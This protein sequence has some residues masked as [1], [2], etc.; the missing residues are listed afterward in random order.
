MSI[1][2]TLNFTLTNPLN[3][4]GI[5]GLTPLFNILHIMDLETIKR[6]K[7][8][9][10]RIRARANRLNPSFGQQQQSPQL[11]SS[12][13]M[14]GFMGQNQ[15]GGQSAIKIFKT[16]PKPLTPQEEQEKRFEERL[17]Q[18][19]KDQ[20]E[21]NLSQREAEFERTKLA[22]EQIKSGNWKLDGEAVSAADMFDVTGNYYQQEFTSPTVG[23]RMQSSLQQFQENPMQFLMGG[24]QNIGELINYLNQANQLYQAT[25]QE[26]NFMDSLLGGSQAGAVTGSALGGSYAPQGAAPR[27]NPGSSYVSQGFA[28]PTKLGGAP[29]YFGG[30]NNY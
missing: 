2:I 11:Q 21:L 24:G 18:Y 3:P 13:P 29:I 28:P 23:D 20:A 19:Q 1:L 25:G 6:V 14:G 7:E 9:N 16:P 27:Y 12:I 5:I 26:G 8:M 10:D 4:Y 17:A 30:A 15:I 22:N